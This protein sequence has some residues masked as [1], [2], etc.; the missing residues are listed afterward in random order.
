[1]ATHCTDV[2]D[3]RWPMTDID[4]MRRFFYLGCESGTFY[5]DTQRQPS[6][7]RTDS[8][9]KLLLTDRGEE[10]I[11]VL[12]ETGLNH[13]IL[14]RDLALSVYVQC[15]RHPSTALRQASYSQFDNIIKNS[16]DLLHFVAL[17]DSYDP[18]HGTGWGRGLRRAVTNWF[19]N[20]DPVHL[21]RLTTQQRRIMKKRWDHR[22]VLRLAHV[23]PKKNG[24]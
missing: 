5:G 14:K 16:Q 22:D 7:S 17:V 2:V 19:N 8:L 24:E 21:A 11:A 9:E 15:A 13:L 1:M 3:Y 20:K 10:L 18:S 6:A 4:R 12:S 23:K